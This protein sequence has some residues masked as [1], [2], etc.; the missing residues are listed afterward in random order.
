[1]KETRMTIIFIQLVQAYHI[2]GNFQGRIPSWILRF[3]NHPWKFIHENLG[4]PHSLCDKFSI[5]QKFSPRNAP[6]LPIRESFL[7]WK[8]PAIRYL[9]V[10]VDVEIGGSIDRYSGVDHCIDMKVKF[11]LLWVINFYYSYYM[12]CAFVGNPYLQRLPTLW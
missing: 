8:F 5:P 10:F 9:I 7:P 2:A 4:M 11:Y 1:M 12:H 6:F 3:Y